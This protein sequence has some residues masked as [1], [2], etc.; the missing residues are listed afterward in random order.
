MP[1]TDDTTSR[2]IRE[3]RQS[4]SALIT[5]SWQV[6]SRWTYTFAEYRLWRDE[7]L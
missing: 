5:T 6:W 4:F 2:Q 3:P 1:F 7:T